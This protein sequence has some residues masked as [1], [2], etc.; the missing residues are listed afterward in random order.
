MTPK[1]NKIVIDRNIPFIKGVFEPFANVVYA[2]GSEIAPQLAKDAD[3]LIIRTRT[4]CNKQT[5]SG[6]TVRII[7]T[8]TIGEDHID[9][10]WC[11]SAGIKVVNCAGCNAR[12]VLQYILGALHA[13]SLRQSW[14]PRHK[15]LG[16]VGVGHVGSLVAEYAARIGMKVICCDPPRMESDPSLNFMSLKELL[17]KCDIV[18]LHVPLSSQGKYATKG[19]ADSHFFEQMRL[20]ATF[21]NCSRGGVM[22]DE[23]L[24]DALEQGLL[25]TA[26]I[27]T[28]NNEPNID[29]ELLNM[30][31]FATPHIA[32]YSL[33][34]KALASAMSVRAIADFYD[35]PPKDWY[36]PEVE[37][38]KTDTDFDPKAIL[39]QMPE[40]FNI[41]AESLVIKQ[42]PLEFES[43]RENYSLRSEYF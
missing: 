22:V 28:W 29:P 30:T 12:A 39:D 8:A 10:P 40:H 18:T 14:A 41:E 31:T 11:E 1:L 3:A 7:V 4:I 2:S 42:K 9:R 15:T 17:P 20:G 36:P 16:V 37:P 19:M 33:Q 5:L 26:I 23:D 6:S 32:G 43:L 35:L 38:T 25:S 27:D 24:K 21:I 34:G 13:L